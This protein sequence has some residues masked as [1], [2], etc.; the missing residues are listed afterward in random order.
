[1][2]ANGVYVWSPA[3]WAFILDSNGTS[4]RYW[5]TNTSP[6]N[7]GPTLV[8]NTWYHL[9]AE[10]DMDTD[11]FNVWV[12]DTQYLTNIAFRATG[13]T[14][15]TITFDDNT[16]AASS[17]WDELRIYEGARG[18]A[19]GLSIPVILKVRPNTLLRM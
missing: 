4:F 6:P 12:N 11:T 3:N 14:V 7:F 1:M 16:A 17:W 18:A 13:L 5:R 19:G 15:D 9:E 2:P 10:L 8:A